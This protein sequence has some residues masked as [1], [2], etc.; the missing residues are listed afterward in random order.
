MPPASLWLAGAPLLVVGLYLAVFPL[1]PDLFA[2]WLQGEL[3]MIELATALLFLTA[4]ISAIRLARLEATLPRYCRVLYGLFG[5]LALFVALEEISY[6]QHLAGWISP[7]FFQRHNQQSETNL[8]NLLGSKPGKRLT[9]IADVGSLLGLIALP[10]G[11][12]LLH[13]YTG[14][15]FAWERY[16]VPGLAL[17]PLA[18]LA[19]GVA[20]LKATEWAS[21]DLNELREL[22]WAWAAWGYVA[23]LRARLAGTASL[24]GAIPERA[25][26]TAE[27]RASERA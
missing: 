24:P 21:P 20:N 19:R 12:V 10:L 13:R 25:F 4:S 27:A 6:G 18:L 23:V 14:R 7:E 3:G 22:L 1:A 2:R 8:H 5:M 26:T 11:L 15:S 9:R 17:A 16:L